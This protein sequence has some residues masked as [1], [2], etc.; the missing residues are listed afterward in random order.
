MELYFLAS[1]RSKKKSNFSLEILMQSILVVRIQSN[2]V[3]ENIHVHVFIYKL[4]IL[5]KFKLYLLRPIVNISILSYV[6]ASTLKI[7]D[8]V[9]YCH[10]ARNQPTKKHLRL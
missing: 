10:Q 8:A 2:H 9:L 1:Q 6:H 5:Q 3:K 7:K 4:R